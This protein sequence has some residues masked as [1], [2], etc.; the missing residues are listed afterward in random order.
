MTPECQQWA[1]EVHPEFCFWALAGEQG[2]DREVRFL[3]PI[4]PEI[5]RHLLN[6]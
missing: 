6:A 3:S 5:Q 4:F 2:G 1:F